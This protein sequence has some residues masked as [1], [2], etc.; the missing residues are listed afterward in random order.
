MGANADSQKLSG[1]AVLGQKWALASD[2]FRVGE[3]RD[4]DKRLNVEPDLIGSPKAELW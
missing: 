4:F 3:I 1:M 2:R